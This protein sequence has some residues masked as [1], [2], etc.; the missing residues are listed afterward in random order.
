MKKF[1]KS[2]IALLLS[3]LIMASGCIFFAGA[4]VIEDYT[5]L[6]TLSA[7]YESNGNPGAISSGYDAGGVSYGAYQFASKAGV[8][9]LFAKW[10]ISSGKGKATGD[11]LVAA[12][13]KDGNKYGTNF[14][15]E[16]K[17]IA[18]EN[19]TAFMI[20]QH[21]YIKSA[22]YDVMISRVKKSYPT[23]D[24]EKYSIALKNVFWSRSVQHG[25]YS[26]ITINAFNPEQE[27]TPTATFTA[28]DA[29]AGTLSDVTTIM[30]Y[31]VD[32][33]NTWLA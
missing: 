30:K 27:P 5:T 26:N 15:N 16:W 21:G 17:A 29:D 8:P 25:A 28:T 6:G 2:A 10:C 1:G 22:Y 3:A 14:N 23:F 12:Y 9:L 13:T 33:G 4:E 19:S 20:L 7:K 31:S 32:G 24:I 18:A 11:R